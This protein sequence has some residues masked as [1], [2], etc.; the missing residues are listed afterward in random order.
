[1]AENLAVRS[2]DGHP[3]ESRDPSCSI[4]SAEAW[5]PALAGLTLERMTVSEG[6]RA[7]SR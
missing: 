1:M 6:R 2:S 4:A 3:G 7:W 5:I